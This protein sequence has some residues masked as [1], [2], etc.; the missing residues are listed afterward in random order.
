VCSSD[1]PVGVATRF[2]LE[3]TAWLIVPLVAMIV[4]GIVH[5]RLFA[6]TDQGDSA[7]PLQTAASDLRSSGTTGSVARTP[8][9]VGALHTLM[10][11]CVG[12]VGIY[13]FST[14]QGNRS[15][16]HG[17]ACFVVIAATFAGTWAAG[18]LVPVRSALW[19]I[20]AIPVFA[21]VGYLWS[22]GGTSLMPDLPQSPFLRI[23]PV[24][25]ISVGIA[26][27]I[28]TTWWLRGGD[29]PEKVAAR[30]GEVLAKLLASIGLGWLL[31]WL[32]GLGSG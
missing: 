9:R 27:A 14:G 29:G 22:S 24:Q 11:S 17:Q 31:G 13:L 18:R 16:Q 6:R 7:I 32:L 30:V 28:W 12:L 4:S 5:R 25:L 15:I 20:L 23:L 19:A 26:T 21:I 3:S 2:A 1:L 8:W 10:A